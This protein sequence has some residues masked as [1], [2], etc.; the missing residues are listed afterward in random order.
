MKLIVYVIFLTLFGFDFTSSRLSAAEKSILIDSF[1]LPLQVVDLNYQYVQHSMDVILS[2]NQFQLIFGKINS[3]SSVLRLSLVVLEVD[4]HF[5][6]EVKLYDSQ[7]KNYYAVVPVEFSSP[8]DSIEKIRLAVTEAILGKQYV[9]DNMFAI[10]EKAKL[11]YTPRKGSKPLDVI[12]TDDETELES[13]VFDK[14]LIPNKL[15][16]KNKIKRAKISPKK[17]NKIS[18]VKK[19]PVAKGP[20]GLEILNGS[21]KET[22]EMVN[23]S[24]VIPAGIVPDKTN[25]IQPKDENTKKFDIDAFVFAGQLQIVTEKNIKVTTTIGHVGLGAKAR[26]VELNKERPK[27]FSAELQISRPMKRDNYSIPLWRKLDFSGDQIT[28][29]SNIKL[30]GGLELEPLYFIA[31]P[32]YGKGLTVVDNNIYWLYL[33]SEFQTHR[34]KDLYTLKLKLSRSIY[35]SS[36]TDTKL[37]GFKIN[38]TFHM[39][40]IQQYS[41]DVNFQRSFLT[42]N[43]NKANNQMITLMLR[44]SF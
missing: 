35:T 14:I 2:D 19:P 26:F 17:A 31:L 4:N 25:P 43:L 28:K 12:I 10:K 33:S 1:S 39:Y 32:N 8:E 37:S 5:Y 44:R 21:N 6:G 24:E 7:K 29:I 18:A 34:W 16:N 38:S 23:S 30:G 9:Q 13:K 22:P 15:K 36:S 20:G 11:R 27:S 42:D 40:L 3:E 41:L